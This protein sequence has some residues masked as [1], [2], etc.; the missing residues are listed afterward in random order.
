[1]FRI[2]GVAGPNDFAMMEEVLSRRLR[3][4]T[5]KGQPMP[6]LVLVDGGKGQLSSAMKVYHEFDRG[7]PLLGLAKRTDLLFY[8]DGR[9]ISLP[10]RSAA[11][12]LLKRIRDESHRFAVTYHRK[13]RGK[14]Q[15]E[16][17]LDSIRGLGP[18]RKKA[19]LQ[20]FGSVEKLRLAAV[21][22]IVKVRGVGLALAEAVHRDLHG[23]E[24][25]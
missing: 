1:R 24:P 14:K 13:L 25:A 11:L 16:S 10:V 5:E 19:L 12:K 4:L 17:E 7:I 22:D 9:E 20:H 8:V 15:L 3:G 23:R 18:V 2:R 6:D 21:A